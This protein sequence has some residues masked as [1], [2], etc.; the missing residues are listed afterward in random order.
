MEEIRNGCHRIKELIMEKQK[1]ALI[2]YDAPIV[3]GNRA[4]EILKDKALLIED[5]KITAIDDYKKLIITHPGA[6]FKSLAGKV[7]FPGFVNTHI[8]TAQTIVRGMAEDMGRAPSYTASVP[9]GDD[10]SEN[11]AYVFSMLG[12]ATALR[13]GSTTISD[14]Y[15]HAMTNAGAF[16]DLGIRA[17]V[18]E[19]VHDMIFHRL[20]DGVYEKDEALG[21]E[22]LF[23]NLEVIQKY[24]DSDGLITACL[25]PH[26]VDTCSEGLLKK[27]RRLYEQYKL[28][29]TIHLDQSKQELARVSQVY[30][31]TS[32]EVLADC[33]LLN[34]HLMAA[35]GVYLTDGEMTL[36]KDAEAHIV[37]I[38]EGNAKA[39]SIA[40]IEKLY[41]LGLNISI[42]TDNGAGNMTENMRIALI[43]ARILHGSVSFP[44]PELMLQMATLNGARALHMEDKIGS[45]EVGKAADLVIVDYDKLHLT[46]SMN[47]FGNLIHL[48]LGNDIDTVMVNGRVVVES[49]H[50]TTINEKELMRDARRIAELKWLK[51]N[52]DVD[53]AKIYV[54]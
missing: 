47:I 14:N 26:A 38:P 33:G 37:H 1:N 18:S 21:E 54:F 10:L 50:V 32:T 27:I 19:R 16:E 3:T 36:L 52:P 8:H 46:P 31:K 30:H 17:V 9:Q 49:G 40:P 48:G 29:I 7:V 25:G 5:G 2:L 24:S 39:G 51:S 13:F 12:A 20:S 44:E 11:E 4:G 45:V 43:S 15:A 42:A 41:N 22:L 35:H 53:K 6:K 28:P 23:K 34:K